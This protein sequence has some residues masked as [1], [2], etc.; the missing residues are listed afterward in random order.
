MVTFEILVFPYSSKAVTGLQHDI[1]VKNMV[2]RE[3]DV[4]SIKQ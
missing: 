3:W 1:V 2:K 4:K